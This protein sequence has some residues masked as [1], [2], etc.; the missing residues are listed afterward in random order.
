MSQRCPVCK[1]RLWTDPL[2]A[3]ARLRCPRCGAEFKSIVPWSYF[4]LLLLIVI[5]LV[6]I[7]ITAIPGRHVGLLSIFI[8]GLLF[9]FWYLP[10]LIQFQRIH[11]N[12][13]FSEGPSP[14]PFLEEDK[15]Q[16]KYEEMRE[17]LQFRTLIYLL[18]GVLLLLVIFALSRG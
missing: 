1:T 11:R 10:R 16:E 6:A 12:L 13:E 18:I 17:R 7:I 9:F 14:S 8:I 2:F 3:P 5:I 15:W 4:K